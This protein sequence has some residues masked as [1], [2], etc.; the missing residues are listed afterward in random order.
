MVNLLAGMLAVG[1]LMSVMEGSLW[2]LLFSFMWIYFTTG[3]VKMKERAR[4]QAE[5]KKDERPKF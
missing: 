2:P 5:R 1:V 3:A 4:Q